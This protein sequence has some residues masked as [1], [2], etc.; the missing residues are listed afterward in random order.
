MASD[1]I[2]DP[3]T[4]DTLRNGV[5]RITAGVSNP[6]CDLANPTDPVNPCG[7]LEGLTALELGLTAAATEVAAG[8]GS[9]TTE[10]TLLWGADQVS[11]GSG[12][13][14]RGAEQ[15]QAEGTAAL[16]A[17]A[18]DAS[19]GADLVAGG[20][21]E[22][23]AG[24]EELSDGLGQLAD[25][26]QELSDGATRA[27]DGSQALAEGLAQL[28]DGARLLSSGAFRAA[29]GVG[30]L[31]D[32]IVELDDG[33]ERLAVGLADA[34]DGSGLLADGQLE[35]ADGGQQIADGSQQLVEEGTTVLADSVSEAT[36][37]SS[38]QLE[39]VRAVAARGVAGDGLPYPTVEGAEA[40]AVYQFELAG[41]G[42]TDGAG[43]PGRLGIGLIA[44][45]AAFA[46]GLV[47]RPRTRVA[48]GLDVPDYE[49]IGH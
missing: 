21:V 12:D 23:A 4:A 25:G 2:G 11:I 47:A 28:D 35:A 43:L 24:G 8:L 3:A 39:Q 45:L 13:L 15:L 6:L 41:V 42:S 1:A 10:G 37:S 26:G 32:G 7:L 9:T 38:M 17:G 31:A 20:A 36:V 5:F 33:A 19:D 30:D 34:A 18:Q 22:A 46:I 27:A 44:L 29:A 40:S 48:R 49:R 16:A 14:A